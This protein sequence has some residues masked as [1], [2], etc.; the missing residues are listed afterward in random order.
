MQFICEL[1][2]VSNGTVKV[3]CLKLDIIEDV[4]CFGQKNLETTLKQDHCIMIE[5]VSIDI[6]ITYFLGNAGDF[7][8]KEVPYE[9]FL[10]FSKVN[11]IRR[12]TFKMFSLIEEDEATVPK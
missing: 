10:S 11:W 7:K 8:Q 4:I 2:F 3:S 5:V 1:N 6:H 12:S 9:S